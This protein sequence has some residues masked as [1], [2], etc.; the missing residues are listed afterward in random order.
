MVDDVAGDVLLG[1]RELVEALGDVGRERLAVRPRLAGRCATGGAASAGLSR[2]ET[3]WRSC[4]RR[5]VSPRRRVSLLAGRAACT[6]WH[7]AGDVVGS[8]PWTLERALRL[9]NRNMI[10]FDLALGSAALL[11]P[12]ATL[13]V[14]GPR[15]ALARRRAPVPPLRPDLAHLRRRAR[16][17]R[18]P[19][20]PAGLVGARLAARHRARHRHRCGRA[21]RPSR[22]R[23]RGRRCSS[24][25]RPTWRWRSASA[26][27]PSAAAPVVAGEACGDAVSRRLT[28]RWRPAP[29]P[30]CTR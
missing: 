28:G 1:A 27:W 23:G 13:R 18:P 30:G 22:D 21:R 2:D 10:A 14:L 7:V 29:A 25:A 26:G 11:A 6:P 20:R 15:P 24:P 17:R 3:W 19:R 12:A 9:T 8:R 16:R 5:H 4:S